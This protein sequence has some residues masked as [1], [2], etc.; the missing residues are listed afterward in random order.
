M[1]GREAIEEYVSGF[2]SAVASTKHSTDSSRA[3]VSR[4]A[5]T[6]YWAG[7]CLYA[8]E[9]GSELDVP[10]FNLLVLDGDGKV[11]KYQVYCDNHELFAAQAGEGAD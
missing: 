7:R 8:R 4:G 2:L 6:L 1:T 11:V 10:F 9:D 3:V 5:T